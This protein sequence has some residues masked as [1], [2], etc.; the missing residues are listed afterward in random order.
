MPVLVAIEKYI[1][2]KRQVESWESV[3]ELLEGQKAAMEYTHGKKFQKSNVYVTKLEEDDIL[4]SHRTDEIIEAH[5]IQ[6][7]E[8]DETQ[9]L[10]DAIAFPPTMKYTPST[11][12]L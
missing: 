12:L 1:Q 8:L 9:L 4:D 3:Q 6:K 7:F 5:K 11:K 2:A 10:N